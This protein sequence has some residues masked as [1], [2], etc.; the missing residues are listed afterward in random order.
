MTEAWKTTVD[1]MRWQDAKAA[2]AVAQEI[3]T[4]A[5]RLG[6]TLLSGEPQFGVSLEERQATLAN[7]LTA[8]ARLVIDI[9]D[10]AGIYDE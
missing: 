3:A 4:A 8:L 1:S 2:Q 7:M 5:D 6:S 10:R 9:D